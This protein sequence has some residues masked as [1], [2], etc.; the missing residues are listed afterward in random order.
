MIKI[1]GTIAIGWLA[2]GLCFDFNLSLLKP[3]HYDWLLTG[4]W[5]FMF[6]GWRSF[7]QDPWTWPIGQL[8]SYHFPVPLTMSM[9]DSI[10]LW[11]TLWKLL[12]SGSDEPLQFFGIW[13]LFCFTFQAITAGLLGN[14]LFKNDSTQWAWI[15]FA[16]FSPVLFSRTG[17]PALC[18]Q[19]FIFLAMYRCIGVQ[20]L[21]ESRLSQTSGDALLLAIASAFHPYYIPLVGSF[22]YGKIAFKAF[23][24]VV[25]KA[26][27]L[28]D[29]IV[30]TTALLMSLFAFGYLG[31]Y[32]KVTYSLH[33][34]VADLA[35]FVQPLGQSRILGP[36]FPVFGHAE[37]F[38][39]LGLG[40]II[41][42]MACGIVLLRKRN[43]FRSLWQNNSSAKLLL[44]VCGI[45]L[46]WS[47]GDRPR[48]FGF[49]L[50]RLDLFYTPLYPFVAVFRSAGRFAWPALY[51]IFLSCLF[52]F[53][54]SRLKGPMRI[55][56][57]LLW[58]SVQ[59]FDLGPLLSSPK[60]HDYPHR[61]LDPQPWQTIANG[62]TQMLLIPPNYPL[63]PCEGSRYAPDDYVPLG[64]LASRLRLQ[65]NSGLSA[66]PPLG[67]TAKYCAEAMNKFKEGRFEGEGLYI[68][69]Q[70]IVPPAGLE[71]QT[72]TGYQACT[73]R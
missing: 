69:S 35:T 52:L 33:T 59:L 18:A 16:C 13:Y 41:S 37:G 24:K 12:Y 20:K 63:D 48:I 46:L 42:A 7:A 14:K 50:A 45:M 8:Q 61:V 57:L 47:F 58:V 31:Q 34:Y 19:G 28:R 67:A 30:L 32:R 6:L 60:T 72:I 2:F 1:L 17:H 56:L 10:P 9:T 62:K 71:C 65:F 40:M 27:T 23:Y 68:L 73:R 21:T 70:E 4:D 15:V 54:R 53:D 49:K 36:N 66:N 44:C 22:L 11:S 25:P 64:L 38:A 5:G 29:L 26:S 55:G 39:Y 43:D 3:Q 51:L